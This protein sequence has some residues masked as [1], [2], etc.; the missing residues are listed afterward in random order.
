LGQKADLAAR[1]VGLVSAISRH[2]LTV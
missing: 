2:P 1:A